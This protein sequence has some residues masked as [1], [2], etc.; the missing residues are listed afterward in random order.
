M[1]KGKKSFIL[2]ADLLPAVKKMPD[3][4]AGELFKLILSYVNGENHTTDDLL[5]DVMFEN[6]KQQ[7]KR[8]LKK[9]E[10]AKENKA[11]GG[12]LGNLK[13]WNKDLYEYV[14]SNKI[15]LEEA[16]TIA[17][18]RKASHTDKE[19]SHTDSN[20]SHTIASVAVNDNVNVNDNVSVN[21]NDINN[22]NYNNTVISKNKAFEIFWDTYSKK[23]EKAP[24]QSK[25]LKLTK[26]DIENILLVVNDYVIST[27]D[28]KYRK[29][30]LTWLNKKCW[31]DEIALENK[32][33]QMSFEEKK[34][35]LRKNIVF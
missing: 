25:F 2:Y 28:V 3:D 31:N 17:M 26:K 12:R 32:P 7:L 5:V 1:A 20:L 16:E 21:V 33:T 34:A 22:I 9:Y 35:E 15:T 27:P 24:C 11:N 10:V 19:V 18:S 8:D 13:R 14:V 30:P 29:N 4:K 6:V 23:V